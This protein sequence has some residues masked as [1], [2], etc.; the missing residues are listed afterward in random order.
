M[1]TYYPII[2][3]Q[4]N[5]RPKFNGVLAFNNSGQ[6]IS[7]TTWTVVDFTSVEI[8]QGSQFLNNNTFKAN[9]KGI[10]NVGGVVV[11]DEVTD[12]KR[13]IV[14]LRKDSVNGADYILGR[15]VSGGTNLAGVGGSI[16]VVLNKDDEI[17]LVVWIANGTNINHANGYNSFS[18]YLLEELE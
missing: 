13:Y 9:K 10:Y 2:N 7:Q 3:N 4:P 5:E 17:K 8:Q 1:A 11:V 12:G 18:A 6:S 15:G 16:R 14:G